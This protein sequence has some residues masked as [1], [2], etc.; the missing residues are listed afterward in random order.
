M[1][2]DPA[3]LTRALSHRKGTW[4]GPGKTS[5]LCSGELSSPVTGSNYGEDLWLQPAALQSPLWLLPSLC[6]PQYL[7][8]KVGPTPVYL[9]CDSA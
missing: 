8:G 2:G 5:L 6:A 3:Q 4:L 1:T 7:K 9:A